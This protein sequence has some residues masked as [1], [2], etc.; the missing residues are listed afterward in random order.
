MISSATTVTTTAQ[1]IVAKSNSFR[2]V[3]IHVQGAGTVYLGGSTV[4]SVNGLLT[5]K[6]AVPLMLEIP[7]QEELWAVT[8]SGTESLR[9]L[10]PDLYNQ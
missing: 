2:T 6:H 4:T 9:L 3:Y 8:A 5:E 1:R 7:A 10:L